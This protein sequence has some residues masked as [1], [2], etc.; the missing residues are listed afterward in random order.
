VVFVSFKPEKIEVWFWVKWNKLLESACPRR[1][2]ARKSDLKS[3]LS[4]QEIEISNQ[5]NGEWETFQ[6]DTVKKCFDD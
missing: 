1:E 3:A 2:N 6:D 4:V 5:F